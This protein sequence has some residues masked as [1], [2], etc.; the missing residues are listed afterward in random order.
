MAGKLTTPQLIAAVV[1]IVSGAGLL[2]T[3]FS[4]TGNEID[5]KLDVA[6]AQVGAVRPTP[7]LEARPPTAPASIQQA[8]PAPAPPAPQ[9][10]PSIA[11]TPEPSTPRPNV[12]A[13]LVPPQPEQKPLSLIHI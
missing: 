8:L 10:A 13:P 3:I 6:P 11:L 12:Q 7:P 1:V 2:A 9:T 4:R 5:R